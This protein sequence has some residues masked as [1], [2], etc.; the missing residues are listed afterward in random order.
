MNMKV[1]TISANVENLQRWRAAAYDQDSEIFFLSS[2]SPLA[3]YNSL[4]DPHL[5][6]FF[7]NSRM[8]KHLKKSGLVSK[9]PNS[10]KLRMDDSSYRLNFD[11][12]KKNEIHHYS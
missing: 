4:Q 1:A 6:G 11:L 12:G 10:S 5:G 7:A 2:C 8:R 9:R 3:S